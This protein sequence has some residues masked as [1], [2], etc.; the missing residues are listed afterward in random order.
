[1]NIKNKMAFFEI[2][3]ERNK[4]FKNSF[5]KSCSVQKIFK[6]V[7]LFLVFKKVLCYNMIRLCY[8][9]SLYSNIVT[10]LHYVNVNLPFLSVASNGLLVQPVSERLH[11]HWVI[12]LDRLDDHQR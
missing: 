7:I 6:K 8:K 1:L 2:N 11:E 5:K 10:F 4:I 12:V 3:F 9:V